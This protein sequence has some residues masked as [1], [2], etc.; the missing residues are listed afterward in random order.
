VSRHSFP[1][2]NGVAVAQANG[3][4]RDMPATVVFVAWSMR[5]FLTVC[6]LMSQLVAN[7]QECCAWPMTL[8][9][10]AKQKFFCSA[11]GVCFERVERGDRLARLLFQDPADTL[12]QVG[13]SPRIHTLHGVVFPSLGLGLLRLLA[14]AAVLRVACVSHP[15]VSFPGPV[16]TCR[17]GRCGKTVRADGQRPCSGCA[18]ASKL[19]FVSVQIMSGGGGF[20]CVVPR[21]VQACTPARAI[22]LASS[23]P[24]GL[25]SSKLAPC[26]MNSS[27]SE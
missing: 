2:S 13:P 15:L 14:Q 5:V 18:C 20:P 16:C 22:G 25:S 19:F 3:L 8:P 7:A 6:K 4:Q 24:P 17:S 26:D 9:S 12:P 27:N 11:I 21:A 1:A 23:V 10:L